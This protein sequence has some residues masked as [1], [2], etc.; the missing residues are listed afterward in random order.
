VS[1]VL[2]DYDTNTVR[3]GK[4]SHMFISLDLAYT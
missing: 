1:I 3:T 2:N 4:H